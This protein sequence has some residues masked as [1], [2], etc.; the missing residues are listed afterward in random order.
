MDTSRA[1]HQ[2]R[3]CP[4][5]EQTE[6]GNQVNALSNTGGRCRVVVCLCEGIDSHVSRVLDG[7]GV[8]C[9]RRNF[10]FVRVMST[11][12]SQITQS[13]PSA[14]QLTWGLKPSN[15]VARR[16]PADRQWAALSNH[17][18]CRRKKRQTSDHSDRRTDG[19]VL[20]NTL[21]VRSPSN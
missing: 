9:F 4:R 17:R 15:E 1:R 2:T 11:E 8:W 3:L 10:I 5:G 14:Q 6:R 20:P 21:H 19:C 13:T 16:S 7:K 12:L 18:Q